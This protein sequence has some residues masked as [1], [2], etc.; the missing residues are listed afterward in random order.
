M[1]VTIKDWIQ[2]NWKGW[3]GETETSWLTCNNGYTLNSF[4]IWEFS[5]TNNYLQ[6]DVTASNFIPSSVASGII[7]S[8]TVVTSLATNVSPVSSA[9]IVSQM[10][11]TSWIA[12]FNIN[13]PDNMVSY[14][15]SLNIQSTLKLPTSR[16]L[17]NTAYVSLAR[18]GYYDATFLQNQLLFI[19]VVWLIIAIHIIAIIFRDWL[20]RPKWML[21]FFNWVL[22]WFE[23]GVYVYLFIYT[24]QII[25]I[26][27]F[28]DIFRFSFDTAIDAISFIVA[29]LFGIVPTFVFIISI[30]YYEIK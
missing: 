5:G 9:L 27:W 8:A 29:I 16:R 7:I 25:F 18:L 12:M 30:I 15:K 20:K 6:K 14:S 11:S 23:F 28:A 4:K 19:I 10:Q 13:T 1:P 2:S 24:S 26:V 22:D 17:L 3:N 21:N